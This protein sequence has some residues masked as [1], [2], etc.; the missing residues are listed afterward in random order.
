[1]VSTGSESMHLD[2]ERPSH[3][4]GAAEHI[5]RNVIPIHEVLPEV[6]HNVLWKP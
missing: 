6:A 4:S 5:A 1:M 3:Y 2:M